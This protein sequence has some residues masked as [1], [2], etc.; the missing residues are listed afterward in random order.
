METVTDILKDYE[1]HAHKAA[2]AAAA[3][4]KVAKE[5]PSYENL[6]LAAQKL[7]F[8]ARCFDGFIARCRAAQAAITPFAVPE[9][10]ESL[11]AVPDELD[12]QSSHD[13]VD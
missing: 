12:G 1:F 3:A 9:W 4:A 11:R 2:A 8:A 13:D 6:V 10:D 7:A 5:E